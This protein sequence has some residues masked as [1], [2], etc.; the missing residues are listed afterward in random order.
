MPMNIRIVVH[1]SINIY[2]ILLHAMRQIHEIIELNYI[3]YCYGL[4][5]IPHLSAL[6]NVF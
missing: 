6:C 2:I 5:V 4:I 1:A 3:L